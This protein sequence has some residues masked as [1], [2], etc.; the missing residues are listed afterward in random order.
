MSVAAKRFLFSG[1]HDEA[2]RKRLV[3]AVAQLKGECIP[4][5]V[6]E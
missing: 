1:I 2:L 5:A 4:G 3:G 6:S